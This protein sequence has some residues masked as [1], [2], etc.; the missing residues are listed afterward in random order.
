MRISKPAA[1]CMTSGDVYN[2][3]VKSVPNFM[4]GFDGLQKVFAPFFTTELYEA[5]NLVAYI[6]RVDCEVDTNYRQFI[7]YAVI[8]T[9]D[10]KVLVYNRQ[11]K[12]SDVGEAGL[13]GAASIGFGGHVELMDYNLN[14]WVSLRRS[15]QRELREELYHCD[16]DTDEMFFEE[17][18]YTYHILGVIHSNASSV[19]KVHLGVVVLVDLPCSSEDLVEGTLYSKEPDQ[20]LNL[21]WVPVEKLHEEEN[22]ESWSVSIIKSNLLTI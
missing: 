18:S 1:M 5:R 14:P 21:R 8:R 20:I 9:E 13:S 17:E 4:P 7:M 19:D 12:D 2:L 6:P 16:V 15:M 3:L 11:P 10:N 22:M